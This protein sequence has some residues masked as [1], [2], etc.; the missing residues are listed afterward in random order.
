MRMERFLYRVK[1][2][3]NRPVVSY[4]PIDRTF[5]RRQHGK[6][7]VRRE[8]PNH[9]LAI[10]RLGCGLSVNGLCCGFEVRPRKYRRRRAI[11]FRSRSRNSRPAETRNGCRA[12]AVRSQA[13]N[14]RHTIAKK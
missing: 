12:E 11:I 6:P 4:P 10:T 2:S 7:K 14:H 8:N 9:W 13:K 1:T 5:L 3:R